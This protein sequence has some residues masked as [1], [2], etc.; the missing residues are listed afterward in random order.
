GAPLLTPHL[1]RHAVGA[2][3]SS[4]GWA[5]PRP[6]LSGTSSRQVGGCPSSGGCEF[7][8]PAP[9]ATS[10]RRAACPITDG[11]TGS[12]PQVVG[13]ADAGCPTSGGSTACEPA[14]HGTCRCG[15][16]HLLRVQASGTRR[17]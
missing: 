9:S 14:C 1:L 2:C 16:S 15:V 7:L 10:S 8:R 13:H 17:F 11:C 3:P 12:D 5:L 4:G 6:A